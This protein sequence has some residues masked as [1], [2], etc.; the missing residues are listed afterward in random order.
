MHGS[1]VHDLPIAQI[2]VRDFNHQLEKVVSCKVLQFI[3]TMKIQKMLGHKTLR[4]T[5]TTTSSEE[6]N[7]GKT[8]SSVTNC[9]NKLRSTLVQLVYTST[10]LK[11]ILL[12]VWG[13]EKRKP[14]HKIGLESKQNQNS[15]FH[16][17]RQITVCRGAIEQLLSFNEQHFF[18]LNLGQTCMS[19]T[20]DLETQFLEVLN[21]SQIY[22]NTSKV[23]FVKR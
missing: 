10:A 7:Q 13:C 5:N 11:I 3:H 6:M 21:T 4:C 1:E 12:Y 9:M 2:P 22:P 23:C 14:K 20:L 16:K 8:L 15:I 17:A 19:S 18:S